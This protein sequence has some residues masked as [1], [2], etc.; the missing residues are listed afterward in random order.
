MLEMGMGELV[1]MCKALGFM[2]VLCIYEYVCMYVCM[3]VCMYEVVGYSWGLF[4]SPSMCE[5]MHALHH[6]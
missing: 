3:H 4:H 1:S 6:C 2:C 5:C